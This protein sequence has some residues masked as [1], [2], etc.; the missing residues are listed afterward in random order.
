[1]TPLSG[2]SGA[3]NFRASHMCDSRWRESGRRGS[4]SLAQPV[5]LSPTSDQATG[6]SSLMSCPLCRKL[7]AGLKA[8]KNLMMYTSVETY[9]WELYAQQFP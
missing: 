9:I 8:A 7:P 1:M 5:T 6:L 3:Y 2:K 4:L